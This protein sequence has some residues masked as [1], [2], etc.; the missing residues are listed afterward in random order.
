MYRRARK[1]VPV[2]FANT[3]LGWL[4]P[5]MYKGIGDREVLSE[6]LP[7]RSLTPPLDISIGKE[8]ILPLV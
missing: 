1:D 5:P 7:N 6:L 8:R 4:Q 3:S 2:F